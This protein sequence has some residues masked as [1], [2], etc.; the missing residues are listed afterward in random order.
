MRILQA[1]YTLSRLGQSGASAFQ[2]HR[3]SEGFSEEEMYEIE[4]IGDYITPVEL[5]EWTD[6]QVGFC[7]FKLHS[8]K[9][10]VAQSAI[11]KNKDIAQANELL[12]HALVLEEG[13]FPFLPIRLYRSESFVTGF[14]GYTEEDIKN[15]L[16]DLTV[17]DLVLNDKINTEDVSEFLSEDGN[18]ERFEFILNTVIE[19]K[20][21]GKQIVVRDEPRRMVKWLSALSF[22][23][24]ASLVADFTFSTCSNYLAITRS[25]IIG[26]HTV[27]D[28]PD[29]SYAEN[30]TEAFCMLFD[31]SKRSLSNVTYSLEYPKVMASVLKENKGDRSKII[32]FFDNFNYLS[33]D[34]DIDI[35][36]RLYLT[37]KVEHPYDP[38][39]DRIISFTLEKGTKAF[40]SDFVKDYFLNLKKTLYNI[41]VKDDVSFFYRLCVFARIAESDDVFERVFEL[42]FERLNIVVFSAEGESLKDYYLSLI[43][44]SNEQMIK[45]FLTFGNVFQ[46]YFFSSESFRY[47]HSYLDRGN[48]SFFIYYVGVIL[49]NVRLCEYASD[50]L[51]ENKEFQDI[52]NAFF[53]H[54]KGSEAI[55]ILLRKI[56]L[57]IQV[58]YMLTLLKSHI[59][60]KEISD[61]V[62]YLNPNQ[63][64]VD[65]FAKVLAEKND[66]AVQ[67]ASASFFFENRENKQAV[68]AK[69]Y[70]YLKTKD[71]FSTELLETLIEQY[72]C[73]D[74]CVEEC[75]KLINIAVAES[76]SK[77]VVTK[78]TL[79]L[80]QHFDIAEELDCDQRPFVVEM[81]SF[82]EKY[83]IDTGGNFFELHNSGLKLKNGEIITVQEVL[84]GM[85]SSFKN[86][87]QERVNS[88]LKIFLPYVADIVSLPSDYFYICRFLEKAGGEGVVDLAIEV[89]DNQIKK[90]GWNQDK[91][92]MMVQFYVN[93]AHYE[94]TM[95][96]RVNFE[97][98]IVL[99]LKKQ[100]TAW[101]LELEKA[102]KAMEIPS[103]PGN[104]YMLFDFFETVKDGKVRDGILKRIY[105]RFGM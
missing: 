100:E 66:V 33:L 103:S 35:L 32:D 80:E 61:I 40:V 81:C 15:K 96:A 12:V 44:S 56:R 94:L 37:A 88:F 95:H 60:I 22:A 82:K 14:D 16:P 98:F 73:H 84:K 8:G 5:S 105:K 57:A 53:T 29:F 3:V 4:K 104:P 45:E 101:L 18:Q 70:E 31:E 17:S 46:K 2:Y 89:F 10:G 97:K 9:I 63:I 83:G 25:F 64:D 69:Y 65:E 86:L 54:A 74:W 68:F 41:Q 11:I 39:W 1:C 34:R 27:W 38:K 42:Y 85:N 19:A 13:E 43:L 48:N 75:Q 58:Y 59:S 28:N 93:W 30:Q 47:M 90:D 6:N 23:F 26:D 52:L 55:G 62:R 91:V 71:E 20:E 76:C 79:K 50:K 49:Q 7:Y 99:L 21:K 51:F 24:P 92:I 36:Y 77:D 87:P 102:V 67:I 78:L 72:K